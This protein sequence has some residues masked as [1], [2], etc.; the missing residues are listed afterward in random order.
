MDANIEWFHF[1]LQQERLEAALAGVNE[2]C[3]DSNQAFRQAVRCFSGMHMLR[4]MKTYTNRQVY[5]SA[6]MHLVQALNLIS[7][8]HSSFHLRIGDL[9]VQNQRPQDSS[10]LLS[11]ASCRTPFDDYFVEEL[12]PQLEMNNVT[13]IGISLTFLNQAFATFRLAFLLKER[14]HNA[15]LWLG[16]PLI[17]CWNAAGK[18]LTSPPFRLFDRV[19]SS[20]CDAEME[21]ALLELAGSKKN[22]NCILAP[23]LDD[24][25]WNYYLAPMPIIP[26]AFSRG[27]YWRRCSFCPDYLHS[28]HE[29][30][31]RTHLANW[32]IEVAEHFPSGAM[33]H[34]TDSAIPPAILGKLAD[35][36][37]EKGL[38]LRW[39]GFARMEQ[40]FTVSEFMR[41]LFEGGCSM[42]QWGM[43][44]ASNRLLNLIDKG[45]AVNQARKVLQESSLAGIKNHI[46][47]LFGLP[48]E[49]NEDRLAT[50]RFIQEEEQ[51]IQNINVSLLNL[52]RSSPMHKN[53]EK[54]G[55]TEFSPFGN[56][57]DLSLY[58]DFRCGSSH[59]RIEARRWLGNKFFR[60]ASVKRILGNLKAPF[61][62]NHGCFLA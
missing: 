39:H 36:I 7:T 20:S 8:Q 48:S 42:L 38:P 3:K 21:T 10:A 11:V 47:L 49:R 45:I 2:Q 46:Y 6:V 26:M 1:A 19:F 34:I 29:I 31:Q 50:L 27:C 33:L 32:L 25:K 15:T 61:K 37:K 23:R 41:H 54:F 56:E 18:D 9:E 35:L 5:S 16:G 58:L 60:D 14:L 57:T 53:P 12:L 62:E 13:H 24:V 17:A 43:E 4:E 40:Q 52:P 22:S 28:E 51:F 55:I 59:P 44:S 30:C